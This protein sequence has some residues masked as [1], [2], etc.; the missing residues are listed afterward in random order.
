MLVGQL[1]LLRDR[2]LVSSCIL[3]WLATI[4][5]WWTGVR[6]ARLVGRLLLIRD[7]ESALWLKFGFGLFWCS[8]GVP[9]VVRLWKLIDL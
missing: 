3:V 8:F 2:E 9:E 6:G 1:L 5:L 7:R 4:I